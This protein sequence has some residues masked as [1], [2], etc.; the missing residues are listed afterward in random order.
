VSR[1]ELFRGVAIAA[2]GAAAL[3]GM[4]TAAQAKMTEK[5]A[6]YQETPGKDGSNCSTC[7]LFQAPSSCTLIDGTI[8]P[9]GW[10]RFYSK[11]S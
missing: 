1:R 9:N 5:A 3:A 11:K 10:C 6:G 2:G 7:A 4:V 8:S